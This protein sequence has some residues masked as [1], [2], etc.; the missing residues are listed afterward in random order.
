MK[1]II[2]ALVLASV[3]IAS[4]AASADDW[5]SRCKTAATLAEGLMK[6]RQDGVPLSIVLGVSSGDKNFDKLME[7]M[8]IDAW[9][10]PTIDDAGWKKTQINE[11]RDKWYLKC[12]KE[13]RPNK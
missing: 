9:E 12:V 7:T 11:F 13:L 3:S 6:Y 10:I 1:K 2:V 8:A 4:Q 5:K